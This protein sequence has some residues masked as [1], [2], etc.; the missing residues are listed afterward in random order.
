MVFAGY[1]GFL[2]HLQLASHALA[3][4]CHNVTKKQN[5]KIHIYL[6]HNRGKK[7]GYATGQEM[8]VPQNKITKSTCIWD[9]IEAKMWICDRSR[10]ASTPKQN[11]KIHIYMGHN[12]GKNVDMRPVKKC[13][14]PKTKFQNPHI[15]AT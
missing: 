3:T 1:S 10:N 2:H 8:Q 5:S 13:K 4:I 12:R 15:S 7:C 11:S 9:I 14:Y 6:G